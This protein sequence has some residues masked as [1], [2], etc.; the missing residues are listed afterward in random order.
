MIDVGTRMQGPRPVDLAG[1]FSV[2]REQMLAPG[3]AAERFGDRVEQALK[4]YQQV[5]ADRSLRDLDVES[6]DPHGVSAASFSA[7]RVDELVTEYGPE[8]YAPY[9]AE[10]DRLLETARQGKDETMLGRVV[11]AFP[12]STA[13][14]R[15]LIERG[16]LL[17]RRGRSGEA[18]R[19]LIQA[20]HRYST[21]V[22]KPDLLKRIAD[23]L[24]WAGRREDAYRWLT[25]AVLEY[26]TATVD[27]QG[28][29]VSF[30]E[31][32]NRLNDVRDEVEPRR[33]NIGPPV[34]ENVRLTLAEPMALLEARFADEPAMR[35]TR[36]YVYSNGSVRALNPRDGSETWP[37]PLEKAAATAQSTIG[38]APL[39]VRE[40]GESAALLSRPSADAETLVR[41]ALRLGLLAIGSGKRGKS[42][43]TLGYR[44]GYGLLAKE[45]ITIGVAGKI[46]E[47]LAKA[48]LKAAAG[49]KNPK[50]R[51]VSLGDW[52]PAGKSFLPIVCTTGEAETVVAS[53]RINLL[54]TGPGCDPGLTALAL[55]LA[56][57]A[58]RQSAA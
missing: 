24:E 34:D 23:A 19:Y 22:D 20:Y 55:G 53:G 6:S 9:E 36:A 54:L 32:R 28:K 8:L 37:A 31:Y 14:P 16:S 18:L 15:A 11:E 39:A 7:A 57:R 30:L 46:P 4:L 42:P 38:G 35:W 47:T 33:P 3:T 13:A 44:V 5:L 2:M 27:D 12:N 21:Q 1:F 10:A 17:A 58:M 25:K 49:M 45:A 29:R 50:A 26:P 56:W 51:L 43:S 40:I 52:L 48:L 41:Q